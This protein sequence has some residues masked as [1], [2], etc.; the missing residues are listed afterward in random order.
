L[1]W[2]QVL[3]QEPDPGN[4]LTAADVNGGEHIVTNGSWGVGEDLEPDVYGGGG[5]EPA[6]RCEHFTPG[7]VL[8]AYANQIGRD[9][10]PGGDAIELVLV[11]LK[12]ANTA[13]PAGGFKSHFLPDL[14]YSVHQCAGYD[15]AEP[16]DGERPVNGQAGPAKVFPGLTL[17]EPLLDSS[18]QF[19]QPLAGGTRYWHYRGSF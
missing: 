18:D 12:T 15:G 10:C 13:L 1:S 3:F 11:G 14:Q 5:L 4:S 9:A 6:R 7:D 8:V 17:V 16:G 19:G 2:A